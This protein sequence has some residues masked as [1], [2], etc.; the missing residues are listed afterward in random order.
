VYRTWS[1]MSA[2]KQNAYIDTAGDFLDKL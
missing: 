2:E 1:K